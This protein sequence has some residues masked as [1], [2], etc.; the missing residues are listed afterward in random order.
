LD[1]SDPVDAR[2][3]PVTCPVVR[4]ITV[5]HAHH[6]TLPHSERI[7]LFE[8]LAKNVGVRRAR[9]A[10]T[11]VT[12][13]DVV[14]GDAVFAWLAAG[15][16]RGGR[17]YRADRFDFV[18]PDYAAGEDV[19]RGG[20]LPQ[21]I[22][23]YAQ[24]RFYEMRGMA[25]RGACGAMLWNVRTRAWSR[26]STAVILTTRREGEQPRQEAFG[27][28][29]VWEDPLV[30]VPGDAETLA[31]TFC[32][33]SRHYDVKLGTDQ[34]VVTDRSAATLKRARRGNRL[35]FREMDTSIT[36]LSEPQMR[37][38]FGPMRPRTCADL[39]IQA[40][41]DFMLMATSDWL[42]TR[43]YP[44][45]PG[46]STIDSLMSV[47]AAGAGLE[48]V[49]LRP[50]LRVY[51]MDHSRDEQLS[52]P[53]VSWKLFQRGCHEHLPGGNQKTA[54]DDQDSGRA[55]DVKETVQPAGAQRLRNKPDWGVAG[56]KI[57]E[58]V[59]DLR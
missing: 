37:E 48:Q 17:Y 3:W 14:L 44:E 4:V 26:A 16:A 40:P 7:A 47:T 31:M 2:G 49:I 30:V 39:H 24:H 58:V 55:D 23:R 25:Q 29:R 46:S 9:G 56:G 50:P 8:Y 35:F 33:A 51:H 34:P 38:V 59:R 19:P 11:L 21:A 27:V 12:N 13:P 20:G 43:G 42:A 22:E 41:G 28:A 36:G 57:T 1:D 5:P 32:L 54:R 6:A 18:G 45:I 52:R 15:G 53:R 10:F